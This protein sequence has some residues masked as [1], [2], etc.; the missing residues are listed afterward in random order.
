M[1]KIIAFANHKGGVCKTTVTLSIAD[2]LSREGLSV[3]VVDLDPQ[4]N[5]TSLLFS[6]QEAPSVPIEK[7]L[8]GSSSIAEAIIHETKVDDVHM[9]GATLKLGKLE[10]EMQHRPFFS[11]TSL[12]H[13]KLKA[14]ADVY[15]V[16]LIDTPPAL[17]FLTA[18]AMIASDFVFVPVISGSKLSLLGTDDMLEFV[19]NARKSTGRLTF[20]GAIL[21][22]HDGRKTMCKI[23]AGAVKSYYG[24]VLAATLPPTTDMHKAEAGGQTI[25][26]YHRDHPASRALVAMAREI[27][28]IVGL[29]VKEIAEIESNV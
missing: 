29:P 27:A 9:I 21:T 1:S 13:E 14:V 5:A 12:L 10:R 19:G 22:Q 24:T 3:L 4:A 18:N 20:G 17:N 11:S 6:T 7:V 2:A 23:G 8:E 25:L 26:Q 15:D 16:I 28:G